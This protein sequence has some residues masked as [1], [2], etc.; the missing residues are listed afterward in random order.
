VARHRNCSA[1]KNW[2]NNARN[3]QAGELWPSTLPARY[4]G[5]LNSPNP[6]QLELIAQ[7]AGSESPPLS[8]DMGPLRGRM[9][10]NRQRAGGAAT[11]DGRKIVSYHTLLAELNDF[12]D[13]VY[14][15]YLWPCLPGY[16]RNP[17][18]R[19]LRNSCPTGLEESNYG[20]R[21]FCRLTWSATANW[22]NS[23]TRNAEEVKYARFSSP[24]AATPPVRHGPRTRKERRLYLGQGP[25]ATTGRWKDGPLARMIVA[26][27]AG[28]AQVSPIDGALHEARRRAR[29]PSTAPPAVTWPAPWKP[30][31][32]VHKANDY[33][34]PTPRPSFHTP[35]DAPQSGKG[36]GLKRPRAAP[37]A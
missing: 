1:E 28:H 17:A 32:V 5:L 35:C 26:Y 22:K 11:P 18:V 29:T 15:P 30:R 27:L 20:V 13:G 36:K 2:V 14:V 10:Q 31:I 9:P 33:W 24:S 7:R 37:R 16:V 21:R 23:I 6:H 3:S 12:I 4:C 19:R 25:R 8:H 34:P